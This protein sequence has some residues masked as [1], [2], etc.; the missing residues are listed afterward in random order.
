MKQL[1]KISQKYTQKTHN[2]PEGRRTNKD[3]RKRSTR[4]G[5]T[6]SLTGEMAEMK[7]EKR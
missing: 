6:Q 3:E 1:K 7:K 5:Q 4:H 2:L